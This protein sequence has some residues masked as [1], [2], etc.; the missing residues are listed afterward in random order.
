MLARRDDYCHATV[1][2]VLY[3]LVGIVAFVSYKIFCGNALSQCVSLR[4]ISDVTRHDKN[5]ERIAGCD[6]FHLGIGQRR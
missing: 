2:S 3:N 4:A 1:T 6:R 5:P